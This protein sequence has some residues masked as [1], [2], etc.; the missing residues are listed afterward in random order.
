MA[1]TSRSAINND[2]LIGL[3]ERLSRGDAA[4]AE[5]VFLS[6]EPYLRMVVRRQLTPR[7]R[8]KFDS[9]DVVQSVWANVLHG[10]RDT[11]WD[12][13][14]EAHLKAFLIRSTL[15]RFI[16]FYR[17][18][19]ASLEREQPLSS[20]TA[21]MPVSRQDRPS[22]VVQA[23]ELWDQL[24]ALSPADHHELLRLKNRGVSLAE[25]ASRTGFHESSIRRI[26]Y[27]LEDR[28]DALQAGCA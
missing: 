14:D 13:P 25:I 20:C 2:R 24:L 6:Y 21:E 10:L 28:F 18:H 17:Q 3:C 12:F 15:N 26:L 7:L 23:D 19:R 8:A 1:V 16:S 22:E 4:A 27:K 9:I 5:E 11:C